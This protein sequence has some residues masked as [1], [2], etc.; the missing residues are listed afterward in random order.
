MR[1]NHLQGY[2]QIQ[3]LAQEPIYGFPIIKN[4][5]KSSLIHSFSHEVMGHCLVVMS[6]ETSSFSVLS[7]YS[8]SSLRHL[9]WTAK[10]TNWSSC[11][12]SPP[13]DATAVVIAVEHQRDLRLLSTVRAWVLSFR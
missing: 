9:V 10:I 7:S 6:L 4:N 13:S 8:F 12:Q 3:V 11:L 1:D 2:Q 5:L